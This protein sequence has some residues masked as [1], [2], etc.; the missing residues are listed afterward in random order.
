MPIA[1]E[2]RA[3]RERVASLV[4][5]AGFTPLDL[6]ELQVISGGG[7]GGDGDGGDGDGGGDQWQV[8]SSQLESPLLIWESCR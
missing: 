1:G 3:S 2:T 7:G 8:L 5:A 6:G 4:T